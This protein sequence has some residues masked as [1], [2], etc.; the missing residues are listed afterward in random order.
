MDFQPGT[1]LDDSGILPV[2]NAEDIIHSTPVK[3]SIPPFSTKKKAHTKKTISVPPQTGGLSSQQRRNDKPRHH[4]RS[5]TSRVAPLAHTPPPS[6]MPQQQFPP[7]DVGIAQRPPA[8]G[9]YNNQYESYRNMSIPYAENKKISTSPAGQRQLSTF[10]QSVSGQYGGQSSVIRSEP[11]AVTSPARAHEKYSFRSQN[12]SDLESSTIKRQRQEIQLLVAEL[13][14]RDRELND[15]MSAHQQQL[16]AWEQDRQRILILEQKCARYDGDLNERNKQLKSA[17]SRLKLLKNESHNHNSTLESTVEQLAKLSSENSHHTTVIQEL[18]EKNQ[19]LSL[20]KRELSNTI[21]QL[22]AREHEMVTLVKL[23]EQDLTSATSHIQELNDRLK[24]L[25]IRCKE[26][27]NGEVE[28]VKQANQWKQK[29]SD[30]KKELEV[31]T[32]LVTR[33]DSEVQEMTGKLDQMKHLQAVMQD[34]F[35]DR[36]KCKEQVIESLRAKQ[37]RTDHQLRHVRELYER[38]QREMNLLQLNLDTTKEIITKQQGSLE[39]YNSSRGSGSYG[40]KSHSSLSPP[41]PSNESPLYYNSENQNRSQKSCLPKKELAEKQNHSY[42]HSVNSSQIPA[43]SSSSNRKSGNS[44][45]TSERHERHHHQ[46][47]S[48]ELV[49]ASPL[50]ARNFHQS[51]PAGLLESENFSRQQ[52]SNSP[53]SKRQIFHKLLPVVQAQAQNEQVQRTRQGT[54]VQPE[55][56]ED[57]EQISEQNQDSDGQFRTPPLCKFDK[58]RSGR[59]EVNARASQNNSWNGDNTSPKSVRMTELREVAKT[60]SPVSTR[61]HSHSYSEQEQRHIHVKDDQMGNSSP[62]NSSRKWPDTEAIQAHTSA[63]NISV[64][65]EDRLS[66]FLDDEPQFEENSSDRRHL[67]NSDPESS[68]GRKLQ[69]L[70]QESKKMIENLEKSTNPS[71]PLKEDQPN[72]RGSL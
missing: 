1:F 52:K 50:E 3:S 61:H 16:L 24:Q 6:T 44:S 18:E 12:A 67:A 58:H 37:G 43:P 35:N 72:A 25:D 39:E 14:D 20:S 2:S 53:K 22:Q 68:P 10:G 65:F 60:I 55:Q 17:M 46:H 48:P 54:L 32:E 29:H 21:G 66:S 15:M 47:H 34:E 42:R 11:G 71:S 31:S 41:P 27:Q 51:L 28:A 59:E 7:F 62:R 70:L 33:R 57:F 69:R 45:R 49:P 38:Q 63:E 8:E 23:K 19:S 5:N 9:T 13:Q 40:S 26:C 56:T 30:L 36:E 4:E 64:S